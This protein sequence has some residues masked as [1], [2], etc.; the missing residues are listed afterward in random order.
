M[1]SA[2]IRTTFG[3]F[4]PSAWEEGKITRFTRN[5]RF[6]TSRQLEVRTKEEP[7]SSFRFDKSV[8]EN[9]FANKRLHAVFMRFCLLHDTLDLEAVTRLKFP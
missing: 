8:A 5:S 9:H 2:R 3:V 6:F 1:S 4:E 7:E